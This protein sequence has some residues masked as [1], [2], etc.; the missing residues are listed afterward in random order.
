MAA[1][2]VKTKK[3]IGIAE[4]EVSDNPDDLLITYSLGSCLGVVLYDKAKHVGGLLH[5][6]LP[7]SRLEKLSR[8][9]VAFNPYKYVD[10]GVPRL[11]KK[12]YNLGA[13]KRNLVLSVFGGAQVFD[14]KDYFNIG[15]R[16]YISLRKISWQEGVLIKNEHVG[17]RVHR[18][19]KLDIQT[20]NIYLDVNKEEIITYG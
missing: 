12:V 7:E 2:A 9:S 17:G 20:G 13:S 3:V 18:T 10:T 6:M 11:F 4:L 16:N 19:V 5:A 8:S 15:K 1:S 14:R